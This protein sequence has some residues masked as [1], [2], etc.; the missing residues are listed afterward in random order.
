MNAERPDPDALLAS[1]NAEAVRAARGH[2]K[3]FFGATAGV[4]KTCAM[5]DSARDIRTQGRDVVI[6]VLETH[7]R[8][9]TA[10]RAEGF[11]RIALREM[12]HRERSVT[13][14]DLDAALVRHPSL[15]LVDELAHSNLAGTRHPKRWQDVEELL[16]AGIDVYT[17]VNVQHLESLNDVVAGITGVRVWETVPDSLFDSANEVV[18]VDLPPE[19]LLGRLRDGK[20]YRGEQA[21]RAADGFF[22]KGNLLALRELALR[23]TADRVDGEV[24]QYRRATSIGPVWHTRDALLVSV[25]AGGGNE[26]VVRAGARLASQLEVPWHA[27]YVETPRRQRL[28]AA[29]RER[30]LRVLE[31]AASLGARTA[32]VAEGDLSGALMRYA[33]NH[34]LGRV[35]ID[36]DEQGGLPWRGKLAAALARHAPDLEI[37]QVAIDEV[38]KAPSPIDEFDFS[39]DRWRAPTQ[40]WLFS[41]LACVLATGLAGLLYPS[42]DLANIAM[43]FLFAVV[44]VAM[45]AGQGPAVLSAFLGVAAFDFFFVPPRFSF[46]VTDA[47]YLLTFA[48]MLTVALVTGQL[49]A[50]LRQQLRVASLREIRVQALYEMAEALSGALQ[51]DQIV[52]ICA[53]FIETSLGA[54][55]AILLAERS[56]E[57]GPVLQAGSESPTVDVGLARWAYDHGVPA[58]R[59]TDTLPGALVL[60]VPLRAPVRIRGVMAIQPYKAHRLMT[61]EQRR[62]LDTCARLAAIALERVHF[63]EVAQE[64]GVEIASERLRNSLLSALSHDL[65]TPVTALAGLADSL[66]DARTDLPPA[67]RAVAASLRDQAFRINALV[68]NL[69]D[70]ARLEQGKV[71]LNRDWHALEE[72]VGASLRDARDMLGSR[73]VRVEIPAD[74]PLVE[75][76][77]VL[78]ERV[79]HNLLENAGKYTPADAEVV[80][81]ARA[82]PTQLEIRVADNGP[83]LRHGEEERVFQKFVRGEHESSVSGVGLGLAICRAILEAHGGSVRAEARPPHG[84]CFVLTLPRRPA[85]VVPVEY[86]GESA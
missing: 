8:A 62:L 27:L 76:D 42:F 22:R 18:L 44:V 78:I 59:G 81:T 11:E 51:T 46:A 85:P 25:G 5:L 57:L 75:M 16:S 33:R 68:N 64:S 83:G 41:V 45:R 19:E 48:V 15:I 65:R 69:L 80:I 21:A 28:P 2:L 56:G 4:G 70:M 39:L 66:A 53:R 26:R 74:L 63:V 14:F 49:M 43:V 82:T 72:V 38:R 36:R 34:N 40:D 37:T 77:A 31:L 52:G 54:R 86:E 29:R 10:Q 79:F 7:G 3:I 23:R 47:Q 71:Q 73:T 32:T 35:L 50:S 12:A 20:V 6:G 9:E 84:A 67:Q 60:Y 13:E 55:S 61:P 30:I 24:Q 17:T 58:G 1:L